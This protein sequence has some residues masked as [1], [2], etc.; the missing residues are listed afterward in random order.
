MPRAGVHKTHSCGDW[1]QTSETT[2]GAISFCRGAAEG[3]GGVGDHIGPRMVGLRQDGFE[4]AAGN[5]VHRHALG[6]RFLKEL[7][8]GKRIEKGP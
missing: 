4:L 1:A 7:R 3:G 2:S 8:I 6:A 5:C